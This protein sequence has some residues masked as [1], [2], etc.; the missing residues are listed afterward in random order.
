MLASVGLG[1]S[2][3]RC[4]PD[5]PLGVE[6]ERAYIAGG[7]HREPVVMNCSGKHAAMLMTCV[8]RGWPLESYLEPDHPLQVGLRSQ[9][10]ELAGPILMDCVDGCG[11]PLWGL[12]LVGLARAFAAL[13][14]VAPGVCDAMRGHP[15]HVG[16]TTRDV[17][18]VMRG[19]PGLLAKDGAE[20]VQAMS[21]D[22]DGQR[23]AV[24]LKIADGSDRA[25]SVVAAEA[26]RF[27]GVSSPVLDDLA[28]VPVL[29]GGR[30]VGQM[31]LAPGVFGG[32]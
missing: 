18:Q 17:S 4:P 6:A 1:P 13:P 27:L 31:R 32:R 29:G 5:W 24:A 25:R 20:A 21:I 23:F 19:V 28:R 10:E 30:P 2:A 9:V 15:D 11:A 12:E 22:V 26:L 14:E 7:G 3:L 8:E 16:G